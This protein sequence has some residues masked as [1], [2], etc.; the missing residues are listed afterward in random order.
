MSEG[1]FTVH[2]VLVLEGCQEDDTPKTY[3]ETYIGRSG[4]L[5]ER[6]K[7][8]A[9][10]MRSEGFEDVTVRYALVGEDMTHPIPEA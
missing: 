6:A 7:V 2:A 8:L 10:E 3:R 1:L 9:E 4:G 5:F